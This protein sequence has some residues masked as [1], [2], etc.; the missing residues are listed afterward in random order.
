MVSFYRNYVML[1][2][3]LSTAVSLSLSSSFEAPRHSHENSPRRTN[4]FYNLLPGID[5]GDKPD[6]GNCTSIQPSLSTDLSFTNSESPSIFITTP[7]SST[8]L[9]WIQATN[10]SSP[11]MLQALTILQLSGLLSASAEPTRIS[12]TDSMFTSSSTREFGTTT[13]AFGMVQSSIMGTD[14]APAPAQTTDTPSQHTDT[15]VT[16]ATPALSIYTSADLVT[17]LTQSILLS[18]TATPFPTQIASSSLEGNLNQPAMATSNAS[19]V[20]PEVESTMVGNPVN[21]TSGWPSPQSTSTSIPS[22]PSSIDTTTY[23]SSGHGAAEPT[24]LKTEAST[25]VTAAAPPTS[26]EAG[27]MAT[28]HVWAMN[29]HCRS[30]CELY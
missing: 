5:D 26:I 3:V 9:A 17:P 4:P 11:T 23:D 24:T 6:H 19:R 7:V 30:T 14:T 18:S 20:S 1:T 22:I 21:Y 2:L 27:P 12:D 16:N 8:S 25:T 28:T 29:F 15:P 10:I 13:S